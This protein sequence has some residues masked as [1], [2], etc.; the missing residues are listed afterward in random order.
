MLEKA[1][2]NFKSNSKKN[3]KKILI[4]DDEPF[5]IDVLE[6]LLRSLNL[7]GL[8]GSVISYYDAEEALKGLQASFKKERG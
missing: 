5:N 7:E 8:P 2:H 3:G 1:R 4:L 6:A